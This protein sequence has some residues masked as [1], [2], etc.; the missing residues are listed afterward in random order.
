MKTRQDNDLV[1][2]TDVVYIKNEN[3]N[4]NNNSK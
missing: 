3:N 4:N 1:N 2:H